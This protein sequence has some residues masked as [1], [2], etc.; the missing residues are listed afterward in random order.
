[1]EAGLNCE[2]QFIHCS[3]DGRTKFPCCTRLLPV[4][5]NI[6]GRCHLFEGKDYYQELINRGLVVIMKMYRNMGVPHT[7]RPGTILGAVVRIQ[8]EYDPMDEQQVYIPPGSLVSI[9]LQVIF[10][11]LSTEQ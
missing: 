2:E 6:D 1:M 10:Q 3:L 7:N 9:S 4:F 5:D 11:N 8:D